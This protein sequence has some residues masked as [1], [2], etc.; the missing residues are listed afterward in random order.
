MKENSIA[1]YD[2]LFRRRRIINLDLYFHLWQELLM[3]FSDSLKLTAR[4][5][6]IR[7][8]IFVRCNISYPRIAVKQS[9][10][11]NVWR[12]TI[13]CYSYQQLSDLHLDQTL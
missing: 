7:D 5:I 10:F 12:N 4:D 6:E 3:F 2:K 9:N 1:F 13:L 8:N 11:F